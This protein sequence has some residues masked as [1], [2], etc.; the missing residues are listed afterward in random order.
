[1]TRRLFSAV[2]ILLLFTFGLGTAMPVRRVPSV[3]EEFTAAINDVKREFPAIKNASVAVAEMSEYIYA[4]T[5]AT[6][7]S[8]NFLGVVTLNE[9]FASDRHRLESSAA[10]D[11]E[12]GF[13]PSL[14]HCT[15]V[16]FIAYHEA[17]HLVD[18]EEG[19]RSHNALFDLFGD[20]HGLHGILSGYSFISA[21]NPIA[22]GAINAP[23]ALAEAFAAVRCS[24]GN[25]AE[26]ELSHMLET[27]GEV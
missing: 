27:R 5:N 14:G 22:P 25:W 6:V 23:E 20:G 3:I 10:H 12:L 11:V 19:T 18:A 16:Q 24:G 21:D 2:L 4:V 1:M 15:G 7:G 17:A 8:K 13:H 9:Y 26:K